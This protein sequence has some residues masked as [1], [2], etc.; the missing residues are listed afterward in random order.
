MTYLTVAE[1]LLTWL[2]VERIL[3]KT[4]WLWSRLPVGVHS[5]DCYYDG[6]D[7]A[8]SSDEVRVHQWLQSVFGKAFSASESSLAL[9][10]GAG[11]YPIRFEVVEPQVQR[12]LP[13]YPLWRE[14]AYLED[15]S[16]SEP[17]HFVLPPAFTQGP[18]MV[19]FHSFKGGVGRTTALMTYVTAR[20]HSSNTSGPVKVLVVDADL[21]APGVTFWLDEKNR[22]QVS[23]VQFLEAMH[24]PPVS[25]EASLN[26]FAEQLR[27]TSMQVDGSQR[28][29]FILPA[30]LDL[31]EI[32]DMPVQPSH[33]ARNPN[34]PWRLTDY[35]HTLGQRLGVDTVFIDLR[36]GLSELA[37]PLIFDPRVEH[38]FVS[39][40][41]K[42]SVL[43]MREVLRRL[44][45]F[46]QAL[47]PVQRQAAKPSVILSL[48]T[49]ELRRLP[50]FGLAKELIEQVYPP[51][52]ESLDEGVEW[53][54]ADFSASLMAIGSVRDAFSLLK[55]S[56]LYVNSAQE[57]AANVAMDCNTAEIQG[58]P[59]FRRT[60]A[61]NALFQV[62]EKEFADS[63][64]TNDWLVTEP[65]QNMGKHF[66]KDI[67]NA[68]IAGAKGA[69]KTFT[70][71]QV[72][73]SKNWDAYLQRVGESLYDRT[74]ALQRIVIPVLWSSNV[75][76]AAK[77]TVLEAKNTGL[78]LLG[79]SAET[80]MLSEIQ[81]KIDTNL[82]SETPQ[83]W[84]DFWSELIVEMLG[85]RNRN[86]QEINLQLATQGQ[87][88]VL[89]FDGLEDVFK[90]SNDAKQAKAIES[91]LKLVNRLGELP[92]QSIGTL[93]FVR[94]DYVQAAIKQNL[95][96]F[97][98]RFSAFA[99]NWNPESF[100]R[101]AYWLCA[102]AGIIGATVDKAQI[103]SIEELIEKLTPLWGQKLGRSDSK[104]GHS[105][106]W[107]YAA[108]C[109]LTGRFQARDLV[110]FFRFAAEAEAKKPNE[111]W[112]DRILSPDVMRKAIPQCSFQKVQEAT[113]EIEP[114]KTWSERMDAER[115]TERTIPF[116][117]ASVGLEAQELV[118]L[119][120]LGVIYE[121]LDPT[122]G[123]KRL[124]L[125]EI[126]RAGLGF[127]LS[128]G[129]PKIQALL[130][131]NL[132]KM[133]F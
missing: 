6:M 51:V 36:A 28:E 96:Q 88:V 84:D 73:Q 125:P 68:V 56:S 77:N 24:Y 111:P 32:Q 129:R 83:H 12:Q 81:R 76:G 46:Q 132:G 113:L 91:L 104:E 17:A 40:V 109:D 74:T 112:P 45:A 108:L 25:E 38:Y 85:C 26:F 55:I 20:L 80:P 79:L 123:D 54:E 122:I 16:T 7:I 5:V 75:D 2:D 120:E 66:A 44:H 64:G 14:V 15:V 9:R 19:S 31:A 95:G 57:W 124:F 8:H 11:N 107:V 58:A 110:R 3:K 115:I 93:I 69:G 60:D 131:K 130:K 117:A 62:C 127:D 105:A 82:V 128:A 121:D 10:A 61:A 90:K 99:L 102:K 126:Y 23:F 116:S 92:E 52:N 22:P 35:L 98:S 78:Q 89:V 49:P 119:R 4:T 53:L 100:L 21:E 86:L 118:A 48:L 87:S 47:P 106:R 103:L 101:L 97:M 1:R 34:N 133:P 13:L 18:R 33:L 29:L 27:K 43:G 67:P 65:L 70:F 37:S 94:L 41:A 72:C 50:D 114:L 71:L 30:A 63:S 59:A 39:T 42:Q